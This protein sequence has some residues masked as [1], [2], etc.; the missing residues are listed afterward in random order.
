M[1]WI[2]RLWKLRSRLNKSSRKRQTSPNLT[3]IKQNS[4]NKSFV[5][6][7]FEVI[8]NVFV[9]KHITQSAK[10]SRGFGDP[11]VDVG[12]RCERIMDN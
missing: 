10:G 9:S 1:L 7:S 11:I 3:P 5:N 2:Q 8:R 12:I 6:F 4:R